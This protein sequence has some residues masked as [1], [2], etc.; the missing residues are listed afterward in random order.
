MSSI[1]VEFQYEI[2]ELVYLKDELNAFC[3]V[4]NSHV[5]IERVAQQ[6]HGG[7]QRQYR[8]MRL[9]SWVPEIALQREKPEYTESF[10][11]ERKP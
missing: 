2:G 4:P 9:D 6:C 1:T 11:P 7:I 10:R 5:I 8:L 3:H